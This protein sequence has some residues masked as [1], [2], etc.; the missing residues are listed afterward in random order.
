MVDSCVARFMTLY[1]PF[2]HNLSNQKVKKFFCLEILCTIG[3]YKDNINTTIELTILS[4][5]QE[6]LDCGQALK[7]KEPEG[8]ACDLKTRGNPKLFLLWRLVLWVTI[9]QNLSQFFHHLLPTIAKS[10][11]KL[12][13][14][15]LA[16]LVNAV[17]YKIFSRRKS[18]W[19]SSLLHILLNSI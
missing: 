1:S 19:C 17:A 18:I 5:T 13:L 10:D 7:T 4:N 9:L 3:D 14:D 16:K 8:I 12:L 2:V 15:K 6:S 11:L